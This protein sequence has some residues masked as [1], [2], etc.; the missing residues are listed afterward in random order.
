MEAVQFACQHHSGSVPSLVRGS[1]LLLRLFLAGQEQ[2][3]GSI[4]SNNLNFAVS[5]S[6]VPSSRRVYKPLV[7]EGSGM[8]TLRVYFI[9]NVLHGTSSAIRTP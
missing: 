7:S 9:V 6:Y 5:T 2:K 4:Y 3:Q 1:L 8:H